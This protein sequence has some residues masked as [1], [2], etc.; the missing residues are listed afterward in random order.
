[1]RPP[2]RPLDLGPR[3]INTTTFVASIFG[4]GEARRGSIPRSGAVTEEQRSQNPKAPQP[5]GRHVFLAQPSLFAPHRSLKDMLVTH[6]SSEPKI[7]CSQ[8]IVIS[9]TQHR[10]LAAA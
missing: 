3:S 1:M 10:T 9:E 6:A 8:C 2:G 7:H 4:S 5:A